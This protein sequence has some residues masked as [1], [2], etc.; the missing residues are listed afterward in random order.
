MPDIEKQRVEQNYKK[1]GALTDRQFLAVKSLGQRVIYAVNMD[2]N[3]IRLMRNGAEVL[4]SIDKLNVGDTIKLRGT[5]KGMLSEN[6]QSGL[7]T[8]KDITD[9]RYNHGNGEFL[10]SNNDT[11]ITNMD[12][13]L[14][15]MDLSDV[16]NDPYNWVNENELN[17]IFY[18]ITLS[19]FDYVR[20]SHERDHEISQEKEVSF[21]FDGLGDFEDFVTERD[22]TQHEQEVQTPDLL[23]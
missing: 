10:I 12:C 15:M 22:D 14:E 9:I 11:C 21:G 3:H 7:I 6:A 16:I 13:G 20:G 8:L 18:Q 4:T 2:I 17:N 5:V 19:D 23:F 1:I